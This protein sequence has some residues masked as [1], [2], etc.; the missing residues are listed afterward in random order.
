M[1]FMRK[2]LRSI[3]SVMLLSLLTAG[4]QANTWTVPGSFTTIQAA[5]SS[6]LVH[7]GDTINVAAGTYHE[8]L[9]WQNKS[10]TIQGAGVGASILD[11]STTNGGPG[12]G[13]IYTYNLASASTL[14]GFTLRNGLASLYGGGMRN[15]YSNLSI[16]D[17][18]FIGNRAVGVYGGGAIFHEGS[19][20]NVV[21]CT[22]TNNFGPSGSGI[23]SSNTDSTTVTGCTF[24]GNDATSGSGGGALDIEVGPATVTNCRFLNNRSRYGGGMLL[25]GS[26]NSMVANCTFEGN[27]AIAYGGGMYIGGN[28]STVANCA[29]RN[30]SSYNGGGIYNVQATSTIINC[31]LL[32]NSSSGVGIGGGGGIMCAGILNHT[33]VSNCIIWGNLSA[34]GA[35]GLDSVYDAVTTVFYSEV[36]DLPNPAPDGSGNF[37]A[38][39]LFVDSANGD[40]RLSALSPCINMGRSD[41]VVSPPFLMDPTNT[42]IIDLDGKPR[43]V[44]DTVDLGAYE[45]QNT[46]PVAGNDAYTTDEDTPLIIAAPGVL[47]N[48]TD[49]DGQPLTAKLKTAPAFG[50]VILNPD[51]SFTYTPDSNFFGT[52]TFTYTVSDGMSITQG[53][54]TL[55]V[56]AVDDPP[57]ARAQSAGTEE[58]APLSGTLQGSDPDGDPLTFAKASDPSHGSV[59][60]N[61][62]GSF[63]Y[64]PIAN[65]N[66]ADSFTF[67]VN[68]GTSTSSPATVSITV[69][70]ANDTPTALNDSYST[71]QDSVLNVGAAGILGNDSDV[72]GDSLTAI[73]VSGPVHGVVTL[74]PDGSFTYTPA[75]GYSGPDSFTYNANDGTVDS[76]SATV[77]ITVNPANH[78]PVAND[79]A[80]STNSG[81]NLNVAAPGALG[82]DTDADGNALTAA[83]VTGPAHGMVTLNA[84]GSFTYKPALAYA[85]P[86]SFTYRTSDGTL[87]SN[88]A[89]VNLTV[90]GAAGQLVIEGVTLK[91]TG[92]STQVSLKIRN[93][94]TISATNV[95]IL[96]ATL[97][98]AVSKPAVPISEKNIAGGASLSEL[99]SF[100]V[101]SGT[102]QLVIS[103]TSSL[104]SFSYTATVQAP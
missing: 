7:A 83:L 72:D 50:H 24:T 36:Q 85:G 23:T 13:C 58:D 30:N 86:D 56:N 64:T 47:A 3:L 43:L 65:Y 46:P 31:T 66:G 18:S 9:S 32:G 73:L 78:A 53:T 44:G 38:D 10:L 101:G 80:Y 100:K 25:G 2:C 19:S 60:V 16:V 51:G 93:T 79:D 49:V 62:D 15:E 34:I 1:R 48:D 63:T 17:C 92:S 67:N 40:F 87:S 26:A 82:N 91:K 102:R 81:V 33:V 20:L 28:N 29:F 6:T 76:A 5:I 22:F 90:N 45:F 75:P 12:G 74:N 14:R 95:V 98:G 94:G 37:S 71:N 52:E 61:P 70:P 11:P 27:L 99:L 4:A 104:G 35:P 103:G 89:T 77:N 97:S 54:V 59:I 84:N 21:N 69:N 96:D 57:K 42:F 55:T 8:S 39:P 68:D 88:T 41:M